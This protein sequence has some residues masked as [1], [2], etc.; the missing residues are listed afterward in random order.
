M[1]EATLRDKRSH[2]TRSQHTAAREGPCSPQLEK[3]PS[4]NEDPAQPEINNFRNTFF[5]KE[6]LG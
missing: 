2:A 1:P 4:S 3:N 6:P 5:S